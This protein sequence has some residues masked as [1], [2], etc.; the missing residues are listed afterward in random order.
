MSRKLGRHGIEPRARI[1][2]ALHLDE[3]LVTVEEPHRL[4]L[5]ERE[6]PF[7]SIGQQRL[8]GT[9]GRMRAHLAR[10]FD[11]AQGASALAASATETRI[12]IIKSS[13]GSKH[14]RQPRCVGSAEVFLQPAGFGTAFV[15]GPS[16]ARAINRCADR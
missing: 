10:P 3:E 16:L 15:A 1:D 14:R 2:D 5:L 4:E 12:A 6:N 13:R 8:L 9:F 7:L 11:V